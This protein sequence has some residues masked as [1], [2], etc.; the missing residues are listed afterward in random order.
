MA[1]SYVPMRTNGGSWTAVEREYLRALHE[2]PT[3]AL[4]RFRTL[5]L[6]RKS[7]AISES[8]EIVRLS[9]PLLDWFEEAL[10]NDKPELWQASIETEFILFLIDVMSGPD[11][12]NHCPVRTVFAAFIESYSPST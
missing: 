1:R 3:A 9:R 12:W 5:F 11:F 7:S 8:E 6:R 2:G 4:D 10:A